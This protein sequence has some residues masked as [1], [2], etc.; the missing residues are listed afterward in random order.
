MR[1]RWGALV[2]LAALV[3]CSKAP[4]QASA[5]NAAPSG[6]AAADAGKTYYSDL[7]LKEFMAH[8]MQYSASNV[9]KYQ[10]YTNNASGEHSL[11][12]KTDQEWEDAESASRTLAEITNLLLQ[13]GRQVDTGKWRD[14]VARVRAVALAE[15]AAAEK[16]DQDAFFQAGGDL[17]GACEECHIDYAPWGKQSQAQLGNSAAK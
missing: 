17:D 1:L 6:T 3:G 2:A 16:H 14:H 13:P 5:N 8:V 4:D 7:P 9:W 10:G 12:P 11:F 15:A